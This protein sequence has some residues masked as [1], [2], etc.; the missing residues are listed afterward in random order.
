MNWA[1]IKTYH[2]NCVHSTGEKINAMQATGKEIS[3]RTFLAEVDRV[4]LAEVERAL[5]Y[6]TGNERGGLRMAND[7]HVSYYRGIYD[8][9]PCVY[10]DHSRIEYIFI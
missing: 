10:F 2:T 1:D 4:S 5:G 9:R 6:D 3:R 8:G 7:W